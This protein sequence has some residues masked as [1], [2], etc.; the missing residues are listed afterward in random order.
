TI[1]TGNPDYPIA[2]KT[3]A[4]TKAT[5]IEVAVDENGLDMAAVEKICK[6]KK[7]TAVYVIPHHHYPTTVTLSVQRRMKL[8][9]LSHQYSFAIIE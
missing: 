4:R 7:I 5:L 1:I 6:K 2:K 9:E 3:F 8:L